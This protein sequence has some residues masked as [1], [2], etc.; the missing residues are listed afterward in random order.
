MARGR[1]LRNEAVKKLTRVRNCSVSEVRAVNEE[2]RAF[3]CVVYIPSVK[4]LRVTHRIPDSTFH[5]ERTTWHRLWL[6]L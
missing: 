4:L 3:L 5:V 6:H 2:G 1:N